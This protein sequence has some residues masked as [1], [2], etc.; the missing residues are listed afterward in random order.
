MS[1]QPPSGPVGPAAGSE[2][3]PTP[4]VRQEARGRSPRRAEKR[5][6]RQGG[7]RL[8]QRAGKQ[9]EQRAAEQLQRRREELLDQCRKFRRE[10]SLLH[11]EI[12]H[13]AAHFH[14]IQGPKWCGFSS[15]RDYCAERLGI[16][17][18]LFYRWVRQSRLLQEAPSVAAAHAEGILGESALAE[19]AQALPPELAESALPG[20]LGRTIAE[21]RQRLAAVRTPAEAKYP[22]A[23]GPDA[24]PGPV[25][26]DLPTET[27]E[28]IV[29]IRVPSVFAPYIENTLRLG[30]ALIGADGDDEM[31]LGAVLA[32]ASS[33]I[34]LT[35]CAAEAL[36]RLL[37]APRRHARPGTAHRVA[38]IPLGHQRSSTV[39]PSRDLAHQLD[40]RL[41]RLLARRRRMAI[42]HEDQL[43][44]FQLDGAHAVLFHSRFDTFAH[45]ELGLSPSTVY[46]MLDRARRRRREDPLA[47]AHATGR[48]TALQT[49]LLRQLERLGVPRGDL[50]RWIDAASKWTVRALRDR[51]A[52]ARQRVHT[53]YRSWS[54]AGC[55]PPTDAELRTSRHSL[56]ELA[57]HPDPP[58]ILESSHD[59]YRAHTTFR[60]ILSEDTAA[61]LAQQ[62][63]SIQDRAARDGHGRCPAWS[64]LVL[65]CH[66]AR[67]AWS[68]MEA[69]RSKREE[70]VLDRDD[71]RC[72]VPGCTRR[73]SLQRHHIVFA[74]RGG[75]N[76]PHNLVTLCAFHHL[77]G[78]HQGL[79]RVQG[80][81]APGAENLV[82]ELGLRQ[83]KRPLAIYRGDRRL[84]RR[85]AG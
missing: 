42:R 17:A 11:S 57:A 80:K 40:L 70:A 81:A 26:P 3:P 9:L 45:R 76:E 85:R 49:T 25:D 36:R 73:R 55:P 82:F 83:G 6:S 28:R 71:W 63:A 61:F 56:R 48:I 60:W 34:E 20:F 64:A 27:S 65:I 74:S 24:T 69:P 16:S 54:L 51:I 14:R 21:L 33:E 50:H 13:T 7:T 38:A 59:A 8:R 44:H 67:R 53:D 18:S 68:Q 19:I 4:P 43:L 78:V 22:N 31:R 47:L 39:F 23:G 52:W 77:I 62:I 66:H 72:A 75:G 41:R 79:I 5:L 1:E 29:R 84:C 37:P 58:G 2:P 32:E 12:C 15:L 35:V 10:P 46:E 30:E